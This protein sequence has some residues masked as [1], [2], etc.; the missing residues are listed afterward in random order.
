M[1]VL[2][3]IGD[4]ADADAERKRA[5]LGP[6]IL[7]IDLMPAIAI[8]ETQGLSA[9]AQCPG[10]SYVDFLKARRPTL[11]KYLG[12]RQVLDVFDVLPELMA[13]RAS[14]AR[15]VVAFAKRK[16][17]PRVTQLIDLEKQRDA[18]GLPTVHVVRGFEVLPEPGRTYLIQPSALGPSQLARAARR[19]HERGAEAWIGYVEHSTATSQ[20]S[21]FVEGE[22]AALQRFAFEMRDSVAPPFVMA[23][24]ACSAL[25]WGRNRVLEVERAR[26]DIAFR[27]LS[28]ESS[29]MCA[30]NVSGYTLFN[31]VQ[32]TPARVDHP[33]RVM[34]RWDDLLMDIA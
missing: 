29:R 19:C 3:R 18:L 13:A 11:A 17:W 16:G 12:L 23:Y 8:A 26:A 4:R 7:V 21:R 5:R 27:T 1:S 32:E 34:V 31:D 24:P 9:A 33:S 15:E 28:G 20:W 6:R 30:E 14:G 10:C 22:D 25:Q 2:V